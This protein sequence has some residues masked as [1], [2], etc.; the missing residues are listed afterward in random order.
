MFFVKSDTSVQ[1]KSGTT[2]KLEAKKN[3]L[4]KLAEND[5]FSCISQT[6]HVVVLHK[7]EINFTII[8]ALSIFIS[9]ISS[10]SDYVS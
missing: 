4:L 1:R 3:I 2:Y 9:P 5:L 7:Y 10:H 6:F 8:L